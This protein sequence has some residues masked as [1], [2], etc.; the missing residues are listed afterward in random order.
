[1]GYILKVKDDKG[2]VIGIPAIKG[3]KGDKGDTG[4][5][6]DKGDTGEQGI[7][8]KSAYDVA[9]DNGFAGTAAQW[10][11]SLKGAKGSHPVIGSNGNWWIDGVDM[12]V[13]AINETRSAIGT[14]VGTAA[15]EGGT[16]LTFDFVPKIVFIAGATNNDPG[17]AA[18]FEYGILWNGRGI[19]TENK[20]DGSAKVSL[21]SSPFVGNTVKITSSLLNKYTYTYIAFGV[22]G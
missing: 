22:E 21:I 10:L 6:G 17:Y 3:E 18:Y 12:G 16:T 11:T 15:S 8:G 1:M 13:R 2:N 20:S 4:D 14:Y 9:V 5:K 7:C 19:V